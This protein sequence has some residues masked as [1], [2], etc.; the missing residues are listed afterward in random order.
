MRSKRKINP[1]NLGIDYERILEQRVENPLPFD[2][3]EMTIPDKVS[4]ILQAKLHNSRLLKSFI[5]PYFENIR[6]VQNEPVI[7]VGSGEG[8]L[9]H[10]LASDY[11]DGCFEIIETE[12][13]KAMLKRRIKHRRNERVIRADAAQLPFRDNYA[14]VVIG[15]ACFDTFLDLGSCLR[16]AYRVL[17]S[18][19][20]IHHIL[21]VEPDSMTQEAQIRQSG[22]V[23]IPYVVGFEYRGYIIMTE[24]EYDKVGGILTQSNKNFVRN[25]NFVQLNPLS[26]TGPALL[27]LL[28]GMR[29]ILERQNLSYLV[30]NPFEY[31]QQRVA[32]LMKKV[33]FVDVETGRL[34]DEIPLYFERCKKPE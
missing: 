2:Q 31:H 5:L 27:E 10:M 30:V 4:P 34:S 3:W 1:S 24:K 17:R 32:H 16:E 9:C 33:G 20:Q 19:G 22:Y 11:V 14:G 12:K 25:I 23:G 13:S 18:G 6:M 26:E 21:D 29:I 8:F 28:E 7:E 15:M